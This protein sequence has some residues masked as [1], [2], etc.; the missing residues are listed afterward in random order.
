[1]VSGRNGWFK[2]LIKNPLAVVFLFA[3]AAL[4]VLFFS[5][6]NVSWKSSS[7]RTTTDDTELS[8]ETN[9]E[10]ARQL[11]TTW[12]TV[13]LMEREAINKGW[14]VYC[15]KSDKEPWNCAHFLTRL[16][17]VDEVIDT[18]GVR[19]QISSRFLVSA[20]FVVVP[21]DAPME[22]VLDFLKN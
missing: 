14:N 11:A 8:Q 20:G 15:P 1:M 22:E 21:W 7:S 9:L 6:L 10:R 19:I 5:A 12:P 4:I 13:K 3:F 17:E 18:Q 2:E 16:L